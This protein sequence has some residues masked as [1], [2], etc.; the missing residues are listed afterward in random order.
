MAFTGWPAEALD[1]YAGLELDNSRAY[2]IAHRDV[3]E[4]AIRAPFAA[5]SD[6][7]TR[8]FGPLHLFR[9]NRDVRFS[10][11]KSPYKTNVAMQLWHKKRGKKNHTAGLY[12]HLSPGQS[13]AG[14]GVWHP[15]TATLNNVRKAIVVKPESWRKVRDSGLKVGGDSL[16]RP[17]VG[18]DPA[19]VF[20]KDLMLKDFTAGVRFR[21]SQVTSLSF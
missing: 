4:R 20:I 17:P 14:A 19:H 15:D 10:K 11:D 13:F 5:L 7:V 18:F 21:N 3:Y 6:E 16:K 1:L 8:E 12:L 9:P 2:W